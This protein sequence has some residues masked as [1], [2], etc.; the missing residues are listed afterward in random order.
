MHFQRFLGNTKA[1]RSLLSRLR[2]VERLRSGAQS[3]PRARNVSTLQPLPL[4]LATAETA[5]ES[6]AARRDVAIDVV[7]SAQEDDAVTGRIGLVVFQFVV[8]NDDLGSNVD[9]LAA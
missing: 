9:V 5:Q 8:R 6:D 2:C 4:L 7:T 1:F 3:R